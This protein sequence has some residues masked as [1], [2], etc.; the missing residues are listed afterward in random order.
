MCSIDNIAMTEMGDRAGRL[1]GS[2]VDSSYQR[3]GID[4]GLDV[5]FLVW[6][7][8]DRF[9]DLSKGCSSEAA[10]SEIGRG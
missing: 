6:N 3:G 10:N 4:Q 9:S 7:P 8:A 5:A 2:Q 1:P